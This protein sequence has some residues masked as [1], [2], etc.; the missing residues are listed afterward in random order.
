MARREGKRH[1]GR[2]KRGVAA[3]EF[4]LLAPALI[5]L[6]LGIFELTMRFRA[7]EEA[8]RYVHQIAD[9]VSRQETLT[10]GFLSELYAASV[11]M[12]APVTTTER[13]DLDITSIGYALDD[14]ATPAIFWRRTAGEE[15]PF[16]LDET[17]G[18]GVAGESVIRVG[19][20]YSYTSFLTNMF[21]GPELAIEEEAFARPRRIRVISMDGVI[22]EDN[23]GEATP[24]S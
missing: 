24:F 4:A 14:E 15:I 3:A 19:V 18:L 7:K 2:D 16:S 11:Y 10:T 5:A 13:L 23:G 6:V 8:T 1:L 9:L 22:D 21:N 20:R 17:E 12:M